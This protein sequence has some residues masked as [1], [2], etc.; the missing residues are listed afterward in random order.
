MIPDNILEVALSALGYQTVTYLRFLSRSTNSIGII[1]P[2]YDSPVEI[3]GSFQAVPKNLYEQF[4]LD[5]QKKYVTFYSSYELLDIQ[6]DVS[7]DQIVYAG[8]RYQV[9][10]S[11][12]WYAQ[13]NWTGV[14][15]VE[16][17]NSNL[18]AVGF[19]ANNENLDN[20]DFNA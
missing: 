16:I 8:K 10:S 2:V 19:G 14:L 6:R 13:Y 11:N 18:K 4:G 20:G 3:M 5:F 15:C 1:E 17:D 9:E 12:D 7:S